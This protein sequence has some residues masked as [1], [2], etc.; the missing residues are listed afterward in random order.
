MRVRIRVRQACRAMPDDELTQRLQRLERLTAGSRDGYWERDLLTDLSWYSPTFRQ[1]LGFA[2]QALPDD[3]NIVNAR[4]HPQD[5]AEFLRRYQDAIDTVGQF[6]YELRY[7]D[8]QDQWRWLRGRGQAWPGTDGRTRWITGAV[9]DVHAEKQAQE[10]L[11]EVNRRFERAIEAS[12]EGLFERIVGDEAV[13][14][15]DRYLE[16]IGN[17]RD[18]VPPLRTAILERFHPDDAAHAL[19]TMAAGEASQQRWELTLRFRHAS[20]EYRWYRQR[21]LS[22]R[23]ADGR[24]KVTGMIADV[25]EQT[26]QRQELERTRAQLEALVAERT[27]KLEAALAL[28]RERQLEAERANAAKSRFLAHMS[29]EIRTP[30][31][32]VIGLVEL[33]QRVAQ[34]PEQQR[35]LETARRSGQTLTDVINTVLDFSRIEAGRTELRP[36]PFDLAQAVVD[37]IRSV[38]PLLRE[39]G[40]MVMFDWTEGPYHV[41]G[42]EIAIRQIVTNLVGNAAKFTQRGAITVTGRAFQPDGDEWQVELC[43]EDTGPGVPPAWRQRIFEAFVQADDSLT[44]TH[45]GTGLGLSIARGL[46]LAMG[47]DITLDDPPAGGSRFTLRL[48]LDAAPGAPT[49]RNAPD[50]DAPPPGMAWLV[51]TSS[52]GSGWLMKRMQRLG[53]QTRIFPTLDTAM[54]A[55]QLG[56]PVQLLLLSEFGLHSGQDLAPLRALLPTVPIQLLVRPD[57]HAPQLEAQARLLGMGTISTPLSPG[58]LARLM[59]VPAPDPAATPVPARAWQADTEVLLVEDNPVNQLIGQEYLRALGL[60]VHTVSDGAQAVQACV[61]HPPALVLMD[62]QMPGMDGFEA[63]RRLRRL[64]QEGRWPG[65]PIVALTAHAGASDHQACLSAGMDGVMTKPLSLAQLRE[66]L[67]RYLPLRP[68]VA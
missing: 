24:I 17:H 21:C 43:I 59:Q 26:L 41:V 13:Y 19:A 14:M 54:A 36:R 7:L 66:Q 65:A 56:E 12:A 28:A 51:A 55:L 45:G 64:Q 6:D 20:G 47:G 37:T 34:S 53:W 5:R 16:L 23:M 25:H 10:S 2:P 42:D 44:R 39:R 3:R 31:N 15:S 8:A 4:M 40:V 38:I 48:P 9:S 57:W 52:V 35:Y 58:D 50:P 22:E 11:A 49:V 29:H 32:G 60:T 61:G 46:A 30:L 18:E 27:A 67:V 68:G 33:A 1:M 63:T 62:L